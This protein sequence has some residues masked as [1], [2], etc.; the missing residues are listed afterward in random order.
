MVMVMVLLQEGSQV[1]YMECSETFGESELLTDM[2][3][4]T[5]LRAGETPTALLVVDAEDY[6]AALAWRFVQVLQ[7]RLALLRG[8]GK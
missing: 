8:I 4:R 6:A 1:G 2:P 5:T 3:S 7:P